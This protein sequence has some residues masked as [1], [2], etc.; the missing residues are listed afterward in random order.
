MKNILK[1]LMI[2]SIIFIITGCNKTTNNNETIEKVRLNKT[3]GLDVEYI[4]TSNN[5]LILKVKNVSGNL[6][7]F[8]DVYSA[9]YDTNNK[10]SSANIQNIKNMYSNDEYYYKIPSSNS[11]EVTIK[12]IENNIE[13]TDYKKNIE[14]LSIDKDDQTSK[15]K[16]KLK[17]NLDRKID[18]FI[19]SL[20][21]YKD[22]KIVDMTTI[23]KSL[24][25]NEKE[26]D[27]Y[28]PV[29]SSEDG[30]YAFVD[31]DDVKAIV[32]NAIVYNN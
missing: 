21:F 13:Y 4:Y 20:L 16:I 9:L 17:N 18:N 19:V 12:K 31:Y 28:I 7:K 26:I 25:I 2:F 27:A 6:I 11:T 15:L 10:L 29:Y 30:K 1:V 8:V 24:S 5:D 23:T 22:G 14:V 32:Q 3:E